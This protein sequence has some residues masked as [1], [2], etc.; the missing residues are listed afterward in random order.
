M[1]DRIP[2]PLR[3]LVATRSFGLCE[4]CLVHEDDTFFGCQ[5]EHVIA[6]KHG[7]A[8]VP[9]NLAYACIYCNAHKGSDIT[10]I[11]PSSGNI[12]RLYNPR[13]DCWSG[14]FALGDDLIIRPKTDVGGATVQLLQF[15]HPDRLVEREV[16][17][18]VGRYPAS[19]AM[20]LIAQRNP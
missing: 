11:A 15:N 4:Y 6:R 10:S 14:H 9:G 7:G 5:I 8:T 16:L 18:D 1:T 17:R 20:K 2:T 12:V 3:R 13:V 19:A